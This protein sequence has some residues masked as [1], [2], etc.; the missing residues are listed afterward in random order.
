MF[1]SLPGGGN[2]GGGNAFPVSGI[3]SLNTDTDDDGTTDFEEAKF[4]PARGNFDPARLNAF[5]Y[6]INAV[7]AGPP[8][9]MGGQAGGNNFVLFNQ[10]AGLLMHE[11]G[12]TLGLGHGGPNDP[13]TNDDGINCKPNY[14]S[15]MNYRYQGGITTTNA[16]QDVDGDGAGDGFILD[17]SPP[18]FPNGRGLAPLAAVDET[19]WVEGTPFDVSDSSNQFTWT[20]N[21]QA[22]A[23][24]TTLNANP[25]WNVDGDTNDAAPPSIDFNNAFWNPAANE[26][27]AGANSCG[28]GIDDDGDGQIDAQDSDCI[29]N[30]RCGPPNSNATAYNG[31]NDWSNITLSPIRFWQ[32]DEADIPGWFDEPGLHQ[33]VFVQKSLQT[34]DLALTPKIAQ[35]DPVVAGQPLLYATTVENRGPRSTAGAVLVDA[36]PE[37]VQFVSGDPDCTV[38]NNGVVECPLGQ[39]LPNESREVAIRTRV[40]VDLACAPGEQFAILANSAEVE[41]RSG[42]DSNPQN[43]AT[44]ATSRVLCARYEYAAKFVCGTQEDPKDPRLAT[45][46]YRTTLNIHNPNDKPAFFFKKLA[47]T[48]PPE[49]QRPGKVVPIAIDELAYDQA[50]KV[51][52][53]EVDKLIE[54]QGFASGYIEGYLVVQSPLVWMSMQ[55]TP[56]KHWV[57][58][59][60]VVQ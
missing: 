15:V 41:N 51:D 33:I 42:Y 52:C 24:N 7:P 23:P 14:V 50:L 30:T 55:S 47:L 54:P 39:L 26:S 34:T 1:S 9:N 6:A 8:P 40:S 4:D 35:P 27:G 25:D 19:A 43:N 53:A 21:N 60:K 48:F 58:E 12:H 37:Y 3:P 13:D 56:L 45:G 2:L 29:G 49:R 59:A 31:A 57:M 18:R 36:L 10:N 38:G 16:G 46:V 44:L 28:N 17:Y 22:L 32:T 5:R 20:Q 11:L